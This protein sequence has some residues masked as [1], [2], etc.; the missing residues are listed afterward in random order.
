MLE[1]NQVGDDLVVLH[2]GIIRF[3]AKSDRLDD[4]EYFVGRMMSRGML[5]KVQ[6]MLR[7]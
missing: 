3:Y 2:C 7:R 1:F 5:L 6:M 4:V